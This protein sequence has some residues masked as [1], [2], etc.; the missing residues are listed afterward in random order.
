MRDL[1][2]NNQGA[3]RM[4]LVISAILVLF[5]IS[6]CTSIENT[7]NSQM[8]PSY[9]EFRQ[10]NI[11]LSSEALNK[12]N[13][14]ICNDIQEKYG[15]RNSLVSLAEEKWDPAFKDSCFFNVALELGDQS[16]CV[17]S[18]DW[19]KQQECYAKIAAQKN[20][21]SICEKVEH[22]YWSG[23]CRFQTRQTLPV[24]T[25]KSCEEKNGSEQDSCYNMFATTEMNVSLCGK[26]QAEKL[27]GT[28]YNA[29]A[30]LKKDFTICEAIGNQSI[31]R[32]CYSNMCE[33]LKTYT[34]DCLSEMAAKTQNE[35]YCSR[36]DETSKGVCYL[37]VAVAKQEPSICEKISSSM[38]IDT[39]NY[40]LAISQRDS[41][42]YKVA[43]AKNDSSVCETIVNSARRENCTLMIGN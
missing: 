1:Q 3:L 41:C 4:K 18:T 11:I 8:L 32:D 29:L 12:K 28:C 25:S 33:T 36:L 20:D 35:A 43:I 17:Y 7:I 24:R 10:H 31:K 30:M 9:E 38:K 39:P 16:A 27:S 21:S 13:I 40:K 42:Y 37:G 22:P 15:F 6:G 5:L 19:D 2:K 23:Y 26:I 14:S 34:Q